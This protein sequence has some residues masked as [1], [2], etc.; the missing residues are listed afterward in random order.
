MNTNESSRPPCAQHAGTHRHSRCVC[1]PQWPGSPLGHYRAQFRTRTAYPRANRELV[2][3]PLGGRCSRSKVTTEP[4]RPAGGVDI[5]SN[6]Y[7]RKQ[8]VQSGA[9]ECQQVA[10]RKQQVE[11]PVWAQH[12]V[13]HATPTTPVRA[14]ASSPATHFFHMREDRLC[15]YPRAITDAAR[16]WWANSDTNDAMCI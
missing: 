9:S 15:R 16:T 6:L 1:R 5:P 13:N 8:T 2:W 10:S 3:Q 4:T 7:V 11:P 12:M 14:N